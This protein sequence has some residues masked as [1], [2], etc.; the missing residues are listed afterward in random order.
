METVDDCRHLLIQLGWAVSESHGPEQEWLVMG[1]NG[2]HV[3]EARGA[4]RLDT[5]LEAVEQAR[6]LGM[7]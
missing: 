7:V 3:I 4:T 2:S 1:T 6:A 5:W